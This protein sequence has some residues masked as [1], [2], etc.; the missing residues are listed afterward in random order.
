MQ[1]HLEVKEVE[2]LNPT[3]PGAHGEEV[4]GRTKRRQEVSNTRRTHIV[5]SVRP[6]TKESDGAKQLN[7]FQTS[8]GEAPRHRA[9]CGDDANVVV[10][11]GKG[12]TL[13]FV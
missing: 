13:V 7:Y 4:Q 10:V 11:V 3:I 2:Y 8:S 12:G 6:S 1:K 9:A 5:K